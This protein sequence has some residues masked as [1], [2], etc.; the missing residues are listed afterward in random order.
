MNT[1]TS[2]TYRDALLVS[3]ALATIANKTYK[4]PTFSVRIAMI[5]KSVDAAVDSYTAI[6]NEILQRHAASTDGDKVVIKDMAKYT[7]EMA[8]V[9]DTPFSVAIRA[10][11]VDELING[12]KTVVIDF[13]KKPADITNDQ[14][15]ENERD[16][17]IP[18]PE[19]IKSLSSILVENWENYEQ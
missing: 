16:K 7:E 9:L 19:T 14:F 17:Y 4:S 3:G 12:L 8:A 10:M 18:T 5:S 15:I 1:I 11:T 2:I 6:R 13:T